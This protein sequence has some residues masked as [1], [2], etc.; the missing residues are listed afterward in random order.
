MGRRGTARGHPS[1]PLPGAHRYGVLLWQALAEATDCQGGT[2][3]QSQLTAAHRTAPID[4]LAVV[5]TLA[6]R[7]MV[8]ARLTDRG[9]HTRQRSFGLPYEAVLEIPPSRGVLAPAC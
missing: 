1:A 4:T 6:N 5:I 8:R 2:L 7:Y 3:Y 9:L